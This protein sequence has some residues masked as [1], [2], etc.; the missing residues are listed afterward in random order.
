MTRAAPAL[1]APLL[2]ALLAAAPGR[3]AEIMAETMAEPTPRAAAAP[4]PETTAETPPAPTRAAALAEDPVPPVAGPLPRPAPAPADPR[5]EAELFAMPQIADATRRAVGFVDAGDLAGAAAVFDALIAADPALG[6]PRIRRAAVAML[7]D[8][9]DAALAELETAASRPF[10][11]LAEALADPI[12]APLA[13]D[14]GFAALTAL[15]AAPPSPGPVP[16]ALQDGV[17]PFGA[18]NVAW[19]PQTER[20]RASF[21]PAPRP[22]ARVLPP[23][24]EAAAYDLL[25]EHVRRGRAAG[26]NGDLYDNRDRGHSALKPESHPQLS[27]VVYSPAARAADLDYGLN[28]SVLFDR[29]TLGNSSTAITGGPLWRSLPRYAMTRPDGAGPMRL[30]QTASANAVYVHP[31]HKD[32]GTE[33]GDLFPANTPYLLVSNGSSGSDQPFLEAV[34]MILAALRPDAKARAIEAGMINSTVQMI[35]RR[36]QQ[37]VT[38]TAIYHSGDAHPAALEGS[39]INLARMVSL[40]NSIKADDLPAEARIRVVAEELGT[41]GVDF[42]GQGLS[43]RLF[44]TPQA[45]ARIWRSSTG[46]REM[47][48]TAEDSRDANGRPLQF[49]WALLQGD[50]DKVKIEPLDGGRRA[51]VTIDWHDPFPISEDNP[52][53]TSRVDIGVFAHNGVHDSAPA[54][55]SWAFPTHE[56]RT[57]ETTPDPAATAAAPETPAETAPAGDTAGE[58]A[59]ETAG[60]TAAGETP[61]G[62]APAGQTPAGEAAAAAPAGRTPAGRA[63]AEEADAETPA[64]EAPAAQTPAGEAAGAMAAPEAPAG[65]ALVAETPAGEAP[66][67]STATPAGAAGSGDPAAGARRVRP[68]APRIVAID[69][70]DPART[71][72]YADPLL[73]PRAAWRDAYAYA[74]DGTL[75]GWTRTRAEAEPETFGPD[76]RR[77]LSD[78]PGDPGADAAPVTYRLVPARNGGFAVEELSADPGL[79]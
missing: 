40:A 29:P 56:T 11:G 71:A 19:D 34:A 44:D 72:V 39:A 61:A 54:I 33:R 45:V 8:D 38:S 6:A 75:L 31:A 58:A 3:A 23:T 57:Y 77:R 67:P 43:E 74:P 53:L 25:R 4:A 66:G 9:P 59:G 55:L 62:D 14:P 76:G 26:N 79:D 32:Y 18:A 22:T 48:L 16:A 52:Q 49:T 68:G 37:H 60:K 5:A 12:F 2:A 42:F 17:A 27:R 47:I 20:L 30:W 41:E 13:G 10:P 78:R 21:A 51:R 35:F 64:G 65:E 63:P 7:A 70:A 1:L 46:R 73:Y 50:P 15:P 69:Y 36:S 24:P 28:D